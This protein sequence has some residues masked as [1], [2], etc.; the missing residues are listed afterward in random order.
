[1]ISVLQRIPPPLEDRISQ[2]AKVLSRRVTGMGEE[3]ITQESLCGMNR[4]KP[5]GDAKGRGRLI[6]QEKA[7]RIQRAWT[8][9]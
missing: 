6:P 3:D 1:M 7:T 5:P 2:E 4:T 8:V 9:S